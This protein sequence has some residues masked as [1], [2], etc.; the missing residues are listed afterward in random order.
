MKLKQTLKITKHLIS[1]ITDIQM[2]CIYVYTK[3]SKIQV[4]FSDLNQE[5]RYIKLKLKLE[6]NFDCLEAC[7]PCIRFMLQLPGFL[8]RLLLPKSSGVP[9]DCS[10]PHLRSS[11]G[12]RQ[13]VGIYSRDQSYEPLAF[14]CAYTPLR[15]SLRTNNLRKIWWSPTH[16]V[17]KGEKWRSSVV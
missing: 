4:K 14:L 7:K 15:E 13:D 5:W 2:I 12:E 6:K 11:S 9:A 10:P 1:L 17:L 8:R 16:G 3:H